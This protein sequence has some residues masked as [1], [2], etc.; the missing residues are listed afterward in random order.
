MS[1]ILEC[2]QNGVYEQ[3][4]GHRSL[5]GVEILVHGNGGFAEAMR[6]ILRESLGL[7]I[8]VLCPIP[9]SFRRNSPFPTTADVEQRIRVVE[10]MAVN[11]RSRRALS[12]AE[13]VHRILSGMPLP[14]SGFP[15]S[16]IPREREPWVLREDFSQG[17]RME[18]EL[19]FVA[20][21]SFADWEN[22]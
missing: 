5:E 12:V 18:I 21:V 14:E 1:E 17:L 22:V 8:V 7:C 4:R 10:E 9:I 13:C 3:L 6:G 11:N 15:Y 2:L 19:S 20:Q 16:L